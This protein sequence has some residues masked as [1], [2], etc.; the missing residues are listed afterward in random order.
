MKNKVFTVKEQV[1]FTFY[2]IFILF[3]GSL[4]F[5]FFS[6]FYLAGN[7]YHLFLLALTCGLFGACC[8]IATY[9]VTSIEG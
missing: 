4:T 8:N 1:N 5:P 7:P 2:C 9:V 6:R 3:L